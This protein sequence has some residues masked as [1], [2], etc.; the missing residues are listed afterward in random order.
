MRLFILFLIAMQ[1]LAAEKVCNKC[2][3]IRAFNKLHPGDFDYYDD[4]LKAKKEQDDIEEE[5]S[6]EEEKNS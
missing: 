6:E 2:E 5:A 4:Y 1:P 3:R